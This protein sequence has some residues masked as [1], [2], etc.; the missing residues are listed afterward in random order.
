[1][2]LWY[3]LRG[4]AAA[5]SGDRTAQAKDIERVTGTDHGPCATTT[6]QQ[7]AASHLLGTEVSNRRIM[8]VADPA[9][10]LLEH[11]A[12]LDR[13]TRGVELCSGLSDAQDRAR[14]FSEETIVVIGID[15][16]VD[17]DAAISALA[18]FRMEVPFLPI[19]MGS[20]TFARMDLSSERA[21][22]A[23][24]SLRLPVTRPQLG[25]ALGAAL[26]NHRFMAQR[27]E[28]LSEKRGA[29]GRLPAN[30]PIQPFYLPT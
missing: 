25:L 15:Y 13:H 10:Q 24:A 5:V 20:V 3:D 14:Q 11:A 16:F 29:R 28:E 4:L 9:C 23:D 19:V 27:L 18:Q 8:L 12:W 30:D 7:V 17:L 21:M 22:I 6:R 1:M 2:V 26:T